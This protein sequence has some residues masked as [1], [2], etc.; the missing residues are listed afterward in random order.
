MGIIQSDNIIEYL[1]HGLHLY[2]RKSFSSELSSNPKS[3]RT[4]GGPSNIKRMEEG[5]GNVMVVS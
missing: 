1:F 2:N 3:I 5:Y 4:V